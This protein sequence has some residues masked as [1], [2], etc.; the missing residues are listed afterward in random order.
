MQGI[1]HCSRAPIRIGIRIPDGVWPGCR[2]V[3]CYRDRI[4]LARRI[5]W[6][7]GRR[8]VLRF[9]GLRASDKDIRFRTEPSW[10]VERADAQTDHVGPGR[11]L[12]VERCPAV[13]TK[14]PRD[15]VAAIRFGVPL[16]TWNRAAGTRIAATD[17]APLWRWQ[18]R[19]WQRNAN[20]TSP[21]LLYRI[22]PH[23]QPPVL[24]VVM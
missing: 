6:V 22:A 18:S 10:I 12:D 14:R 16:V 23:R 17:A 24:V 7:S 4:G 11:H 20:M 13:T 19:Q 8:R 5:V 21:S 1:S 9:P 15:F 3:R 2:S